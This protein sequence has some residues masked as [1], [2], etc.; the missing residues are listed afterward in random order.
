MYVLMIICAI[1]LL[2]YYARR[3]IYISKLILKIGI[4]GIDV[5]ISTKE[6]NDFARKSNRSFLK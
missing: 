2:I 3:D 5:Q 6:K 4:K 1:S